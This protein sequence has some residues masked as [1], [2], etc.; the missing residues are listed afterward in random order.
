MK[1]VILL[2]VLVVVVGGG[3]AGYLFWSGAQK[4]T[5]NITTLQEEKMSKE[6]VGQLK[7]KAAKGVNA[8]NQAAEAAKDLS[9]DEQLKVWETQLGSGDAAVRMTALRELD[10]LH[11]Q[12]ATKV[13]ALVKVVTEKDADE[14]VK[15][16][17]EMLLEEWTGTGGDDDDSG[18]DSADEEEAE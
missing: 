15:M 3:V 17:A 11:G 12:A 18:D 7:D 9:L 5:E 4:D 8:A 13:E 2:A 1:K 10:K 14:D 16:M 6:E